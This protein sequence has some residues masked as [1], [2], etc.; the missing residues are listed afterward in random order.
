MLLKYLWITSWITSPYRF[1]FLREP[2]SA[3]SLTLYMVPL[4][5]TR[6]LRGRF[7]HPT[8]T[9][10][11]VRYSQIWVLICVRWRGMWLS[12]RRANRNL[13]TIRNS[14][15]GFL[16]RI[17]DKSLKRLR[18][19]AKYRY[20]A[21]MCSNADTTGIGP[22][23]VRLLRAARSFFCIRV[24]VSGMIPGR[25]RRFRLA[26]L[27]GVGLFVR[28]WDGCLPGSACLH[29]SLSSRYARQLS[30]YL[31]YRV[32]SRCARIVGGR[33]EGAL[34]LTLG[35]LNSKRDKLD[36]MKKI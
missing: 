3:T 5:F 30:F 19:K 21:H 34:Q 11:Q 12:S 18:I 36:G 26:R 13:I 16:C 27:V 33:F 7:M 25:R 8:P 17:T 1:P 10:T 9:F 29:V 35:M 32:L 6:T 4:L 24:K 15:P 28:D 14:F 22:K 2:G 23:Y 20:T 31:D